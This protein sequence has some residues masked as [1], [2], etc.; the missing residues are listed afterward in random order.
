MGQMGVTH[1]PEASFIQGNPY[2]GDRREEVGCM[3]LVTRIA[4]ALGSLGALLF[5]GGAPWRG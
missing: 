4:A 2:E 3:R 5:A 1:T